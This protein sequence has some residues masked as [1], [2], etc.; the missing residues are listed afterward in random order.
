[1]DAIV[2]GPNPINIISEHIEVDLGD[3]F[4]TLFDLGRAV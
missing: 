3:G 2:L 4:K 1:M